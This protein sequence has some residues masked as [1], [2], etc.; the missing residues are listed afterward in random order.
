MIFILVHLNIGTSS[1]F[2][3]L[4]PDNALLVCLFWHWNDVQSIFNTKMWV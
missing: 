4:Q 1:L 3:Q 2:G